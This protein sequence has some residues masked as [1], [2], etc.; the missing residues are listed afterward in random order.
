MKIQCLVLTTGIKGVDN[1]SIA[2]AKILNFEFK[3]IKLDINPLLKYFPFL[4]EFFF[5]TF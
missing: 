5:I 1:Q 3:E 2:L 4:G